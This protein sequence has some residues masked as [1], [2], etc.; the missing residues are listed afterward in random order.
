MIN[1]PKMKRILLLSFAL[2]LAL[3]CGNLP[4][5]VEIGPYTLTPV[6]HNVFDIEDSNSSNPAG[7][8]FDEQ[9]NIT[10]V[11]NCSDM[12]LI[13]GR[14]KALLIDLSNNVKWAPD[15]AESIH[16]I[17]FS[18]AG[19]REKLIAVTHAHGDHTGMYGAFADDEDITY[20]LPRVDFEHNKIFP[21]DRTVLFE[22][23]YDIDLGGE[24]VNTVMV[25][26]HTKGSMV[27]SLAGRNLIFS[28]DA[29]GSGDGVW[30]FSKEAFF[31]FADGAAHLLDFVNDPSN[32]ID[33]DE[34]TFCGG[35]AWQKGSKEKLGIKYLEDMNELVSLIK[36]GNA[37]WEPYKVGNPVLNA[38]FRYGEAT[39]TWNSDYYME[40]IC[41][42]NN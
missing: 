35:H 38:N 34:L 25:P 22:E 36:Q 37:Q 8:H 14:K 15:A 20:L 7:H 18:L 17:F 11:N 39:I 6:R 2:L 19:K 31:Q 40:C 13:L 29:I 3:S 28:G 26:G 21:Q 10:G 5:S 24:T 9:G 4:E 42:A 16:H 27:Y 12:Y 33:C 30:I 23:G 1:I 41:P 32:G